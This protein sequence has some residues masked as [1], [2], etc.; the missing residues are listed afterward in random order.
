METT[1]S[2]AKRQYQPKSPRGFQWWWL[3]WVAAGLC[4]FACGGILGGMS[5]VLGGGGFGGVLAPPFGGAERVSVLLVG[6]DNSAGQGLSDTLIFAMIYPKTGEISA[7]SIP[8]DSRVEIPNV[9]YTRINASHS[10]G[11]LSLTIQV[12]EGLLGLPV[13][14]YV[15]VNVDGLVK[16]VDA[17]GGVDLEVEKRMHYTDRAQ[18]LYID[19]QPGMQ[20]LNGTQAMGYVRFRHDAIGDFGRVQRQ[21][22]FMGAVMEKLF[23]PQNAAQIPGMVRTFLTTVE[24]DLSAA[25]LMALKRIMEQDQGSAEGFRTATLPAVPVRVGRASMLDLDP[26][27]VREVVNGVLLHQGIRVEVLNGTAINGLAA[28]VADQLHQQGCAIVSTGNAAA[29]SETTMVVDHGSSA[30]RAERVAQWLG[31]GAVS[32]LPGRAGKRT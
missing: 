25:D 7:I 9:G 31:R 15:Q 30:A 27:K 28:Q 19:L 17:M 16:L 6:V 29:H 32:V 22:K 18:D 20:H 10:H 11:G 24:T 12:V 1:S 26:V 13:D 3:I 21:R 5:A 2:E 23:S 4:M 8:R 14:H